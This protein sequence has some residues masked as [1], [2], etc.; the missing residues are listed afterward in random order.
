M[1]IFTDTLVLFM[2]LSMVIQ[3]AWRGTMQQT[4]ILTNSCCHGVLSVWIMVSLCLNAT[5]RCKATGAVNG[6][7]IVKS[8][9]CYKPSRKKRWRRRRVQTC[10][11]AMLRVHLS[12]MIISQSRL[13]P[14][15]FSSPFRFVWMAIASLSSPAGRSKAERLASPE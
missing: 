12:M 1:R 14:V 10:S 3:V 6:E 2:P 13:F 15:P 4:P 7:C 11:L 5:T 9:R 8:T